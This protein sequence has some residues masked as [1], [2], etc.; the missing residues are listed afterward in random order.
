VTLVDTTI[1]IDILVNDRIWRRWSVD[2]MERRS[3]LGALVITD[4]VYAELSP[5]FQSDKD[6]DVALAGLGVVWQRIPPEAL[7]LAGQVFARYR[8]GG[9]TGSTVLGDFFIGAHAHVSQLALLTRDARRY[10]AYFPE[11]KLITPD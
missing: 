8:R 9:G 7:F 1:L 6:L 10:R 5:G 11:V 3:G 2:M 4:I